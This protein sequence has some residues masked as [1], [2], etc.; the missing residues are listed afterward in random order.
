MRHIKYTNGIVLSD[1]AL[2]NAI[3]PVRKCAVASTPN[4]IEA[5]T[6]FTRLD[7]VIPVFNSAGWVA[8]CIDSVRT[9]FTQAGLSEYTI[10]VVD[11]GSSDNLDEVL[12]SIS[13]EKI[14]IIR[15][16]NQGRSAARLAG[17]RSS[18]ASHV[19]F[20]DSRVRIEAN[21]IAFVLPYL[22]NES[23][24]TWTSDVH[25]EVKGNDLARF[26]MVIERVFWR[27]Y[28][29]RRVLTHFGEDDF[30][31]Y[32]KGTTAL[33][34][35]RELFM[36]ATLQSRSQISNERKA[37]DDTAILRHIVRTQQIW[38]SPDYSCVYH[39]RTKFRGFLAHA[40]HRGS[41][42]ID[43]HWRRGA[44]LCIPITISLF[45]FPVLVVVIGLFP[46]QA[47]ASFPIF[48]AGC[49][50]LVKSFKVD[51]RSA[52]VFSLIAPLFALWYFGGML[53]GVYLRLK[54]IWG[55][56]GERNY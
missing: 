52:I 54:A 1:S 40:N 36:E 28:Y 8:G 15:Q 16:S 19:L 21:S 18:N 10:V 23:S 26:W 44:L 7:V 43:G 2:K 30:D 49:T 53:Y 14:S 9:A 33:I 22:A 12:Q 38:I 42:L 3:V 31:R 39:A 24:S 5:R 20:I 13:N 25:V 6:L 56:V 32:P 17:A 55:H 29:R 27:K 46:L 35:Q 4:C 50:L 45:L 51:L 47:V 11:D 48:V 41:V 37:N 34:V